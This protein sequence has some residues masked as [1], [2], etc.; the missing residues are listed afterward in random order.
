MPITPAILL[1]IK[2]YLNLSL[3][4]DLMLWAACCTAFFGFLRA[5]EFT[6]HPTAICKEKFLALSDLS[7]DRHPV[8]EQ[9][10]IKLRFSKTDQFGKGC[11]LVFVRSTS[12]ICPVAAMM[13]YLWVRGSAK[14]P[15]FLNSDHTPLTK[16]KLNGRLQSIFKAAGFRDTFTMHSFRV[17]AATTAATLGFPEYLIKALGRWSS[18]AYKVYVKLS[19]Q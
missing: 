18:D 11:T 8:P 7:I 17:G 5:A 19:V 3:H 10:F 14:G 4:D 16:G 15:L 1:T 2:S 6:T 12:P 13:S 9:V